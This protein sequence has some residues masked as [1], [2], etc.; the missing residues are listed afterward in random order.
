MSLILMVR[1]TLHIFHK[2]LLLGKG[3][4]HSAILMHSNCSMPGSL[5]LSEAISCSGCFEARREQRIGSRVL[6]LDRL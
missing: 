4:M 6:V 1:E 2:V 5:E 3:T